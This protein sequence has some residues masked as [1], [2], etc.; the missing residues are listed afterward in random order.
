MAQTDIPV[1]AMGAEKQFLT[2]KEVEQ[3]GIASQ[4]KLKK[5]RIKGV[6][7]PFIYVGRRVRYIAADVHAWVNEQRVTRALQLP[8]GDRRKTSMS[9][10]AR[11]LRSHRSA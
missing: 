2:P 7:I 11:A 4:A 3:L 10:E 5:D 8:D 6:G 9:A 1:G